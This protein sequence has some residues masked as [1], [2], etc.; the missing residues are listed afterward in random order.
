MI[1]ADLRAVAAT[2]PVRLEKQPGLCV[3]TLPEPR[4]PKKAYLTVI[5]VTA[6]AVDPMRSNS[7]KAGYKRKDAWIVRGLLNSM[8]QESKVNRCQIAKQT[9]ALAHSLCN[10]KCG[11]T[12]VKSII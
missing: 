7:K 11:D 2:V 10:S 5:S 12:S 8:H 9:V 3:T 4:I 6:H 1:L